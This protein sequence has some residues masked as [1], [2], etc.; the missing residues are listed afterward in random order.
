MRKRRYGCAKRFIYTKS[1]LDSLDDWAKFSF[2]T[3]SHLEHSYLAHIE[4]E[5]TFTWTRWISSLFNLYDTLTLMIIHFHPSLPATHYDF[6]NQRLK[7]LQINAQGTVINS[8]ISWIQSSEL[9]QTSEQLNVKCWSQES[10]VKF[11]ILYSL[12]SDIIFSPVHQL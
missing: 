10:H 12:K 11:P 1:W 8:T 4:K 5:E 9:S 3:M 7:Q 6:I 2:R